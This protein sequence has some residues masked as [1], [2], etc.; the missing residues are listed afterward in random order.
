MP[1]LAPFQG[2]TA[3]MTAFCNPSEN[4]PNAPAYPLLLRAR[5]W[6]PLQTVIYGCLVRL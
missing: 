2:L 6:P 1:A 5:I 3:P 4:R